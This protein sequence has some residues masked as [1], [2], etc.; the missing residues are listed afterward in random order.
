MP[1][2]EPCIESIRTLGYS[3]AWFEA[4]ILDARLL[5]EQVAQF[6]APTGDKNTEHYRF[7]AFQK[8]LLTRTDMSDEALSVLVNIG[9]SDPALNDSVLFSLVKTGL[10]TLDQLGSISA[11]S[12]TPAFRALVLRHDLL[13][14]LEDSTDSTDSTILDRC[15]S[16]GDRVVQ[17]RL[18]GHEG[19][20]RDHLLKLVENGA[21]RSV[22]NR[23]QQLLASRRFSSSSINQSGAK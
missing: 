18:L 13:L 23:A 17:E 15:I 16:D 4:G 22:Q 10:L 14:R 20:R 2:T 5:D 21:S 8:H 9:A 6:R 3:S 11:K 12:T 7:R 1:S 19:L